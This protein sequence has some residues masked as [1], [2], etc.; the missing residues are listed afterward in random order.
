[1]LVPYPARNE[2]IGVLER[3]S[4]GF[5]AERESTFGAEPVTTVDEVLAAREGLNSVIVEPAVI[6]YTAD[7][8]RSTRETP[9]LTLGASPRAG[10][11]LFKCAR[12][13]AALAG[14]DFVTPDDV[15]A[16]APAVLRHRVTLAPEVEIE[17]RSPDDVVRA[18]LER[19]EV[20]R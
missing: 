1:V 2:E 5:D 12:A 4:R 8:I 18:V 7:V 16:M 15:K 17:G 10:V 14:R 13:A 9:A 3:Y 11:A 20:P 6:A 19:V